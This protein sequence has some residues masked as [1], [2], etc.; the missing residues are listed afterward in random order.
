MGGS[1]G[2]AQTGKAENNKCC[3][4]RGGKKIK[5]GTEKRQLRGARWDSSRSKMRA[6]EWARKGANGH[7]KMKG[8]II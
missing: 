6:L 5:D 1:L 8:H 7:E 3:P 2:I 4:G